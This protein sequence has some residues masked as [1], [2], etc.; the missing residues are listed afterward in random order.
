MSMSEKSPRDA[1]NWAGPVERLHVEGSGPRV[2]LEGKRL[3]GPQQGFGRLWERTFSIPMG[4]AAT[5]EAVVA[6]WR[7]DFGSFWPRGGTFYGPLTT[8]KPGDVA[9]LEAGIPTGILV[10]YADDTSFSFL[11]PEGHFINGMITFS[12]ERHETDG[13]VAQITMLIRMSDPLW[14][15]AWPIVK[16]AEARFWP[17]TLTNLAAAHGVHDAL[18]TERTTIVDPRRQWRRW[19][20]VVH[21]GV[22]AAVAARIGTAVRRGRPAS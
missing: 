5:P 2:N 7:A 20:N 22:P 3:A 1:G 13:T 15:L 18:V 12:A 4:D 6:R 10:L 11:T 21:N 17:G 8:I 9:P 19:P 14:E 16:S